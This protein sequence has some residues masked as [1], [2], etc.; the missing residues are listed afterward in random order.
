MQKAFCHQP[1]SKEIV[2]SAYYMP[3]ALP[4]LHC[5]TWQGANVKLYGIDLLVQQIMMDDN[6]A[7]H[8]P[9]MPYGM[10]IYNRKYTKKIQSEWAAYSL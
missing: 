8:H 4:Y 2:G 9:M 6:S 3:E 10:S 5:N 1:E 7:I